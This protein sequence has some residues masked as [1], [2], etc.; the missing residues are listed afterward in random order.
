MMTRPRFE[1]MADLP[2]RMWSAIVTPGRLTP[3]PLARRSCVMAN[4]SPPVRSLAIS[5][6]PDL[7]DQGTHESEQALLHCWAESRYPPQ[8]LSS[9]HASG[10]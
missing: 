7:P 8:I 9:D 10:A 5:S 6:Q 2:S 3:S 4:S 1:R